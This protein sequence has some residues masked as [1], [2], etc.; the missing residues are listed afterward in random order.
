MDNAG[1]VVIFI[2]SATEAEAERVRDAL[3]KARRAACVSI[4]PTMNSAYWWQGRTE[5]AEECLLIVKTRAFL[6]DRVVDLVRR[7][8]SYTVPEIVALP[9]VGGNPEYLD[10]IEKEASD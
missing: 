4:I 1:L 3:L 9:V 7:N 2:T 10:W 5:T 8:H 6:I